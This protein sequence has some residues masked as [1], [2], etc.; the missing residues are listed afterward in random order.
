M[1]RFRPPNASELRENGE[2]I[3][4]INDDA[5]TVNIRGQELGAAGQFN[6]D[7]AFKMGT[8]QLEVFEFGVKGIVD[9]EST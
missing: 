5:T 9:G 1:T 2:S 7:K 3:V 4:T 6:F 8:T